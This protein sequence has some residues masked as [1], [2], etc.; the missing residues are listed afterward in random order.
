VL[1]NKDKACARRIAGNLAL[2][3]FRRPVTAADI[4]SLMPYF[5]RG[6]APGFDSGVEQMVAAILV[7]PEFLFRAIKIPASAKDAF[8]L[9]DLSWHRDCRS[10]CGVRVPTISC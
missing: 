3:A 4:D 9:S 7:S 6:R 1:R 5:D 2:E 10:S 8:P